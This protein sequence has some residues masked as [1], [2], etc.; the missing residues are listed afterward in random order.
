MLKQKKRV[1]VFTIMKKKKKKVMKERY[2]LKVVG[3]SL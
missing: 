1:A 2:Y 3:Y